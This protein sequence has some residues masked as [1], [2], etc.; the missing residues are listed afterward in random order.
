MKAEEKEILFIYNSE[1]Q[2]DRKAFGYADSIDGFALNDKDVNKVKITETQ[3]AE[4]ADDMGVAVV[5]LVDEN[6]E[7]YMNEL[8]GKSINDSELT[9]ILSKNPQAIKTPIAYLGK[10]AFFVDSAYS[11][12]KQGIEIEGVKS[13]KGNAFEKQ[14]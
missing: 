9:T 5:Q 1:K 10:K 6:S 14:V 3:L 8:K 4:I 7:Y 2:E 11:F 12:V 13:E